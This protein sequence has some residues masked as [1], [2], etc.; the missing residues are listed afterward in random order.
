MT[1]QVI[2]NGSGN[3]VIIDPAVTAQGDGTILLNGSGVIVDIGAGC[4]LSNANI[5]LGDNCSFIV[6]S[7]CRLAA[8]EVMALS[9][10]S[11]LIGTATSFTWHT[12]FFLHEPAQI[13]IGSGCL[14]ASET[15]FSASD[16]HSIIDRDSGRRINPPADIV[17][18]DRVWIAHS[19]TVLKGSTI[20]EGSVIGLGSVVAGKVAAHSLATGRPAKV[21]RENI[22]WCHELL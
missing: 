4:L 10:G 22:S 3:S 11:V 6:G 8:L 5:T 12:R 16:M 7:G 17:L 9:H 1:L 13:S 18:E 20:G 15:L 14:I 2:D 19:V 21:V